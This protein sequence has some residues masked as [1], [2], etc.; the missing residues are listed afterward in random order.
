MLPKLPGVSRFHLSFTFDDQNRPIVRD[1]GSLWGTKVT[2]DGEKGESRSKFDWLLQ[3]PGSVRNEGKLPV[4]EVTPHIQFRVFVPP[5]DFTSQDHIDRVTAFRQGTADPGG[6]LAS[7]VLHSGSRT[8]LP[9]GTQTPAHPSGTILY[10]RFLGN[11]VFGV[12]S[13]IWNV[14]TGE[15]YA[16][17]EPL[18]EVIRSGQVIMKDW[19]K[20]AN[21]MGA[22]SHPHIVAFRGATYAPHPQL[23]FEYVPGGSLDACNDL[24][25]FENVQVLC[26]LLSALRYLHSREPPI[27]HRDIKPQNILVQYH[28]PNEIH[29]KFADFGLAKAAYD[30]KTFCGT[31]LWMAPEVYSRGDPYSVA[32]DLWSLGVVVASKECKLP[33]QKPAYKSSPV[34]WSRAVMRHVSRSAQ[35]GNTL[36]AFILETM[37]VLD[38]RERKDAAY[39]HDAALQLKDNDLR[40]ASLDVAESIGSESNSG[41]VAQA[42]TGSAFQGRRHPSPVYEDVEKESTIRRRS[43]IA[44]LGWRGTDM[45]DSIINPTE[46][47]GSSET[48]YRQLRSDAPTPDTRAG[49][50]SRILPLGNLLEGDL[51]ETA[52]G[53]AGHSTFREAHGVSSLV[54]Q[55]LG[56]EVYKKYDGDQNNSELATG[57]SRLP[58]KRERPS[59]RSSPRLA[60]CSPDPDTCVKRNKTIRATTILDGSDAS[61]A[62]RG[63]QYK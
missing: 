14:T 35:T 4:L 62:C 24:S 6:M 61:T 63:M 1:L 20:E 30:L 15:E 16:V 26:Q 2:Y 52:N 56:Q 58:H 21:M 38:P 47:G 42:T 49:G 3:A 39:C 18:L 60:T 46:S 25:T 37:L 41:L 53:E 34:D 29:V 17:K 44:D 48:S 9:S 57:D 45:I 32:V 28:R 23:K 54:L 40:L 55:H 8:T 12:V 31:R 51:Q 43:L 59:E 22:L 27:S 10:K 7:L 33:K 13:Y 5:R 50:S 19:K 36:L 11:G